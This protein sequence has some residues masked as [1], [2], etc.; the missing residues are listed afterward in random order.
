MYDKTLS[1]HGLRRCRYIVVSRNQE[2]LDALCEE[3]QSLSTNKVYSL[4]A[5]AEAGFKGLKAEQ[6]VI[7][8]VFFNKIMVF[9]SRYAPDS[10]VEA[11]T[12]RIMKS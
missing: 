5:V 1:N 2:K 10:L 7:N 3:L 4:A 6:R 8:P 11:I 9:A 12:Y